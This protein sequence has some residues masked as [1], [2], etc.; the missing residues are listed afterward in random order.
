MASGQESRG[1][2]QGDFIQ[3]DT[4]DA[5]I[6]SDFFWSSLVTL[7]L[8]MGCLRECMTWAEACRCHCKLMARSSVSS[9]LRAS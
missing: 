9:D 3:V 8:I 7:D 4:V 1:S 6:C 5:A 2:F